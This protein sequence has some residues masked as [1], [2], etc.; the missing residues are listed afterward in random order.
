MPATWDDV[1]RELGVQGSPHGDLAIDA[2][3]SYMAKLRRIAVTESNSRP[4]R[5]L[6]TSGIR[7]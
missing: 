4:P 7:R 6:S 3:A 2:G 5:S 1:T